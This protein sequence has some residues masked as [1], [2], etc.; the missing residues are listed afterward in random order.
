MGYGVNLSY[1]TALILQALA[2]GYRYG[3]DIMDLTGLPSGTVYPALRRL[4]EAEL[5]DSRWEDEAIAQKE[6]R[7]PRRYY[8][9]T[10]IGEDALADAVKRYRAIENIFPLP[11]KAKLSDA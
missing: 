4:E 2:S 8:E 9:L 6:Q 10:K 7:P 3:F 1:S 11:D 5:V